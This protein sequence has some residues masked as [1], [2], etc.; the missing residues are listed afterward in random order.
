M[1]PKPPHAGPK[2]K[3]EPKPKPKKL[4]KQARTEMLMAAILYGGDGA[5]TIEDA[6]G[7]AMNIRDEWEH[8]AFADVVDEDEVETGELET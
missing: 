3:P 7:T 8:Q 1:T 2:P 6:V 5:D 4:D